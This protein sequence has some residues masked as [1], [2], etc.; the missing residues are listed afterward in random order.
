MTVNLELPPDMEMLLTAKAELFG[1]TLPD[2]I[3]SLA[4]ADK[5]K[6][7]SLT[8]GNITSVQQGLT[9]IAAEQMPPQIG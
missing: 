6:N 4:K 8:H 9:E 2:Y 1:M 3:I 5:D 7:Y